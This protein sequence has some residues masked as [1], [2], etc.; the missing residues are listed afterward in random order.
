M[1]IKRSIDHIARSYASLQN[2]LPGIELDPQIRGAQALEFLSTMAQTGPLFNQCAS[3]ILSNDIK[4]YVVREAKGVG[5]G[6]HENL[7]GERWISVDQSFGFIDSIIALGHEARHL[8][9]T[10]RVRCSVEGEYS[11]WR[12]GFRLRAELASP[13][14]GVLLTQDEQTLASM[15]DNP[16]RSDLRAAQ[17]LMQKMAGP[18]YVI[19][20]AP[21]QGSDWQTALIVPVIRMINSLGNRGEL[22]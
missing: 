17:S 6:W 10:I 4:L 9:Q 8:Q 20:K 19:G 14:G 7:S 11:A 16:S 2:A 12:F 1:P 18:D 22:L 13:G 15:P 21:L 5:A 3:Y